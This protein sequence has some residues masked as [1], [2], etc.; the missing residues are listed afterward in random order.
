M[1]L[2]LIVNPVAGLGGRVGLKGSDGE[3]LQSRARA[4]GG[5]PRGEKRTADALR[6]MQ[7]LSARAELVTCRGAMGQSVAARCG[8]SPTLLDVPMH[9][10]TSAS[11]TREA[12][13]QMADRGAELILFAGGDGT[14][15]DVHDAI[16]SRVPVLGIPAGVKIHSAVFATSPASAARIARDCIENGCRRV[17]E[18]EVVDVDEDAL[19]A[20]EVRSRLHGYMNVPARAASL[21]TAKVATRGGEAESIRGI[22]GEL[23]QLIAS[24]GACVVGPGTTTHRMLAAL[25]LAGTLTGVD[26]VCDGKVEARDVS[27]ARLMEVLEGRRAHVVVT[28][29][30]GQGFLF[31]RGDLQIGPDLLRQVGPEGIVVVAT[32]GKLGS[33]RNRPLLV[34]TGDDAVDRSLAGYT[35]VTTGRGE[36]SIY[37]IVPASRSADSPAA[38][39]VG[40][41]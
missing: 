4:M 26:V 13:C 11:D 27:E 32:P 2:G 35:A 40:R 36:K 16:G 23:Q 38:G 15:R 5:V 28:P 29:I 1:R 12:A 22:A 17:A 18:R 9:E 25:G 39:T 30:G 10:P 3:E 31:G 21:Q 20:G 37:R 33:L 6:N 8:W 7:D 24:D 14:A 41:R 34:D 19:R